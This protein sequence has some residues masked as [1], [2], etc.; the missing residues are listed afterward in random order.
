MQLAAPCTLYVPAGQMVGLSRE[1]AH[2]YPAGQ[3]EQPD[4]S[5]V[6]C[7]PAP[8]SVHVCTVPPAL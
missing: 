2:M 4:L 3:F 6:L 1:S 5:A 8:H 7:L